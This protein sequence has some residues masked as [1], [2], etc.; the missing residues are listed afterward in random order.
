M[1]IT[2]VLL[3]FSGDDPNFLFWSGWVR[4]RLGPKA[5]LIYLVGALDLSAA[6]RKMLESRRIQPIDLAK[7]QMFESW[8]ESRR[9]ENAHQWFLESLRA[10]EPYR[11]QRW[12]RPAAGFIPPAGPCDSGSRSQ[13][14]NAGTPIGKQHHACPQGSR[15]GV[16]VAAKPGRLPR[17]GCSAL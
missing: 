15:T 17:L 12:P 3:G 8:P 14:V 7:L 6:K 9:L 5:P 11:A 4:D 13:I 10:V 16:A 2:L 1:E